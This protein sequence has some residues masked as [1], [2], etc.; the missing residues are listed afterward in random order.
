M[1][2]DVLTLFPEI[3]R[4]FA[5]LALIRIAREKGLL[6]LRFKDLRDWTTDPYRTVDD[7]P[8]GGG[9]GMV[10]KPDPLVACVEGTLRAEG[11]DPAEALPPPPVG[12]PQTPESGVAAPSPGPC[13]SDGCLTRGAGRIILLSPQGRPLGQPLLQELAGESWILVLC[14]HYEGYDER[15]R[16]L[17][18]PLEVS[19]GDY[20]L[21]GGEVAAPVL[22]D[23]I[24]RLLPGVLGDP[25]SAEQESFSAGD[26]LDFPHYT[27]PR[28]FR[29]LHVPD[30]LLSGDH[31][32]IA[33]WRAQQADRRTQL[34]NERLR[35]GQ[36]PSGT[37]SD[38]S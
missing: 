31:T 9:P 10:L 14:G 36:K 19:V 18:R 28:E 3:F 16:S 20:V 15:V 22:I 34:R 37:G 2:I 27:R 8:F 26:H 6:D 17:L 21:S 7:R 29:G 1:R 23:G 35:S 32:R 12:S 13:A 38:K 30:V 25:H 24:V 33:S 5:E 11:L 4:G